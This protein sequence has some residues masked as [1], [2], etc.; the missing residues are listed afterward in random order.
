MRNLKELALKSD[1]VRTGPGM[2]D[3]IDD[4]FV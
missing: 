1:I 4:L 3:E 2:L